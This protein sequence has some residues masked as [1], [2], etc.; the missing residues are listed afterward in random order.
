MSGAETLSMEI[1]VYVR[2]RLEGRLEDQLTK[3]NSN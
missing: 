2:S 3:F 1:N